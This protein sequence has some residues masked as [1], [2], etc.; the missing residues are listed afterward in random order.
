MK[1]RIF[2]VLKDGKGRSVSNIIWKAEWLSDICSVLNLETGK[3]KRIV[4]WHI[5]GPSGDISDPIDDNVSEE[6]L[7]VL[8]NNKFIE[9]I[10]E[11]AR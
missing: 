3:V 1:T 6:F 5:T 10:K 8:L 11:E 9:E 2:K 7:N 4:C